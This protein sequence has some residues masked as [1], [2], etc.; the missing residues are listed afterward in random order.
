MKDGDTARLALLGT[1]ARLPFEYHDHRP[2]KT[3]RLH[4]PPH[5][6]YEGPGRPRSIPPPA[7]GPGTHHIRGINEKRG[8]VMVMV[9]VMVM[10]ICHSLSPRRSPLLLH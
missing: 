5:A 9:M 4:S 7:V 2:T 3:T 1:R 8:P 10:R 6:V